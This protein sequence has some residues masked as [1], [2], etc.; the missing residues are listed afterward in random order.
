M[1]HSRCCWNNPGRTAGTLRTLAH[2]SSALKAATAIVYDELFRKNLQ[3]RVERRDKNLLWN[4]VFEKIDEQVMS[5]SKMRLQSI[6]MAVGVSYVEGAQSSNY[7]G[8]KPALGKTTGECRIMG[9]KG[10]SIG[11]STFP[12]T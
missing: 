9:T 12:P 2:L 11:H 4:G 7:G 1:H 5:A 10:R 8:A 3:K 6:L